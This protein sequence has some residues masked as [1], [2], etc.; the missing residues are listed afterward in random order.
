MFKERIKTHH[1]A[2][3]D[4][5]KHIRGMKTAGEVLA[6]EHAED[7]KN[8]T[9]YIHVPFCK[10]ICS[11]CNMRRSL[12]N[13]AENYAAL[14]MKEIESYARLKYIKTTTFDAVYF[15]GGT[16]TT[17]DTKGLCDILDTLKANLKFT[18]DAEFTIETT[19]TELTEEKM[20]A[21]IRH[22]VNRFSVGVQTFD[23]AGRNL[24]GRVG[25]GEAA[26][27]RLKQLKAYEGVTV[28][29]DLIYNYPDQTMESLEADLDKI[30]ELDLDGFS[31]Y[32][33]INM[34]GATIDAAQNEENDAR[35][36][37][38]I[39]EKMKQHGYH[40][41]ELTKM[42]KNDAYKYIMNRH[43][44]ADTL[45]LGA[46]AGGSVNHLA[47]MNPIALAE[48]EESIADVTHK[49]GMLFASEY[50]EITRFK[51][52]IQTIHLPENESLYQDK[53]VYEKFRK[54]L[55]DEGMVC[56]DSRGRYVLTEKGIF[57][58]N[59]ISRKLADML[60]M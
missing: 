8:A 38:F 13:P 42:V 10:K 45:P 29:M 6:V 30:L 7:E 9:I 50:R 15:G 32:S 47:M 28:S 16:P 12:Q 14:V 46:G 33:L 56:E 59:T 51:G 39:A 43:Q 40:F 52:A 4:S 57:W 11:F 54:E 34:K 41:L 53:E 18:A 17:L 48:Y 49:Q 25:S 24:M 5:K 2:M 35:M 3:A 60:M 31:M 22:G 58:G 23:D 36:F 44:G 27:H 20:E 1:S 37:Y 26:Y 55:L 21:L 19:V